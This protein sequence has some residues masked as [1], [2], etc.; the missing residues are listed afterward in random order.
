MSYSTRIWKENVK[1][2]QKRNESRG[3]K[4]LKVHNNYI[5]LILKG[6]FSKKNCVVLSLTRSTEG[7]VMYHRVRLKCIR[8]YCCS[9]TKL[10]N[11]WQTN[12]QNTVKISKSVSLTKSS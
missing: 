11:K 10:C 12:M 3:K 7:D 4:N 2:N 1:R 8:D 6:T 9:S 5:K